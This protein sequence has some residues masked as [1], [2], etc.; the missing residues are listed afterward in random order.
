MDNVI[1]AFILVI[2]LMFV[3]FSIFESILEAQDMYQVSWQEMEERMNDQT[4]TGLS[5]VNAEVKNFGSTVELTLRNEGT[6]KMADFDQWDLIVHHYS[7][8]AIY[9]IER[10]E[11]SDVEPLAG[12]WFVAGFYLDAAALEDEVYEPGIFNPGEEMLI[13]FRVNPSVDTG[14]S[15]LAVVA[16]E[17]GLV[18]PV[19]FSN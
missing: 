17:N 3:G 13:R 18:L 4:H 19:Q 10:L 7:T 12:E 1:A 5:M 2:L 15:N 9:H 6:T 8:G 11:N 14:T 16:T